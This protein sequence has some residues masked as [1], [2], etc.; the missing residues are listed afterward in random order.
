[1]IFIDTSAIYALADR[2]DSNH[3]LA[4]RRLES[5]LIEGEEMLT[6]NYVLVESIALIHRRCGKPAALE[7]AGSS[8]SF[9]IEWV[10]EAVHQQ[11]VRELSQ[12]T[13]VLSF[14]DVVSFVVMRRRRVDTVFAF[15]AD[16]AD[17][18][19]HLYPWR[20]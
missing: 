8:A 11:A 14:V 16:F 18:G 12:T 9:E 3:R 2:N 5:I 19:F 20:T 7:L 13:R 10:D 4:R 17:H 15:D 6:H 1:M